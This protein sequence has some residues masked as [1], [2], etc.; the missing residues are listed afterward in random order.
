MI[1][2]SPLGKHTV[3]YKTAKKSTEILGAHQLK[4]YMLS[5]YFQFCFIKINKQIHHVYEVEMLLT[6]ALS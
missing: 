1:T 3:Q 4:H 5:T 6:R 2:L